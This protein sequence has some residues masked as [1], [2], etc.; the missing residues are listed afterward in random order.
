[1]HKLSVYT[2][3][4]VALV[5]LFATA[6]ARADYNYGPAKNGTQCWKSAPGWT[7]SNGG[8][9]GYWEACPAPAAAAVTGSKRIRRHARS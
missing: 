1:M 9:Y 4:T 2:V 6:P 5:G 3:A 8:M 7:G